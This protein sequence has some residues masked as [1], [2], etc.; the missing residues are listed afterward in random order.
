M[1]LSGEGRDGRTDGLRMPDSE[2][3]NIQ[4]YSKWTGQRKSH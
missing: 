4:Q 2:I 1:V 3:V